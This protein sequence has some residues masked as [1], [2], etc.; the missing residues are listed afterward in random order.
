M[1][2]TGS[3][4]RPRQARPIVGVLA[5]QGNFAAHSSRLAE[6]GVAAREIRTPEELSG[7][8]ALV[9]PGGETTTLLR[10][11][12]AGTMETEIGAFAASGKPIFGTCAGAIL[13]AREVTCPSQRSLALIDI[14]VERNGYGRQVD[15]FITSAPCSALDTEPLEMVFIRAPIIRNVGPEV[16]VLQELKG[17]PVL[18][19]Q[20]QI[21]AATFHP[22]LTP[23]PRLHSYFLSM[24]GQEH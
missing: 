3:S 8:D 24:I 12:D 16:R 19:R 4:V 14:A 22:E 13:L 11:F 23:D 6:L 21:L 17:H 9:I 15:S 1:V 7:V 5:L 10:F 20:D 2:G 18:V